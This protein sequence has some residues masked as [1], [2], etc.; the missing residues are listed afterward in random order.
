M[1]QRAGPPAG[2]VSEHLLRDAQSTAGETALQDAA[3]KTIRRPMHRGERDRGAERT[4]DRDH[5]VETEMIEESEKIIHKVVVSSGAEP[6]SVVDAGG[7]V[8][9]DATK[10]FRQSA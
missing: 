4:A 1:A 3:R 2:P 7:M 10:M 6:G 5:A 8:V 9:A